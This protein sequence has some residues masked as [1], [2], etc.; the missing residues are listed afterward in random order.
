MTDSGASRGVLTVEFIEPD[1]MDGYLRWLEWFRSQFS[2]ELYGM[3]SEAL[4]PA[5]GIESS[6]AL[7]EVRAAT[8]A[9][10]PRPPAY[11][12]SPLFRPRRRR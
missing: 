6:A 1:E 11:P 9:H 2:P 7:R 5:A 4:R 12:D 10:L 3:P 8:L